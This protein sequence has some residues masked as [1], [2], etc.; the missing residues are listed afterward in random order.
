MWSIYVILALPQLI[1]ALA[2]PSQFGDKATA[3]VAV[4]S[5]AISL[6]CQVIVVL[7]LIAKAR[8]LA[9]VV[10][11]EEQ[12]FGLSVAPS[13]FGA[14]LFAVVGLYFML[15]G[16]R[17]ACAA[18]YLL[19]TKPSQESSIGYLWRQQPDNLVRSLGG[20]AAGAFVFFGLGRQRGF[21]RTIG[22]AYR[23][24]FSLK[25]TPDED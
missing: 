6:V 15:D 5:S 16:F 17:H 9:S 18:V 4:G 1:S 2:R 13:E 11:P 10:F 24:R 7:T 22:N 25:E 21:W 8:W 3:T 14:I 12:P 23:E 19:L 20:A